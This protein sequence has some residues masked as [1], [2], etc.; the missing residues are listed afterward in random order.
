MLKIIGIITVGL[1][2]V[3]FSFGQTKTAPANTN[4]SGTWVLDTAKTKNLPKELES[5]VVKIVQNDE[6]IGIKTVVKGDIQVQRGRSTEDGNQENA[7]G[8][9]GRGRGGSVS[10]GGGPS[11]NGRIALANY[12]SEVV[13][14][15]DEKEVVIDIKQGDAVVGKTKLKAKWKKDGRV[16]ETTV[17]R[18][19]ERNGQRMSVPTNEKLELADEGQTLKISRSLSM[20]TVTD[21]INLVFAKQN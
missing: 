17:N 4:F 12:F 19:F 21:T 9:G 11:F 20:P 1:I 16:L 18:E 8:R 2:F 5:Y 10:R 13:F 15:L 14:T 7:G 3:I 6:R